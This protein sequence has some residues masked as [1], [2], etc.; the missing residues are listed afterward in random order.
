MFGVFDHA[1]GALSVRV[2]RLVLKI[3]NEADISFIDEN[4]AFGGS[5]SIESL[6]KNEIQ[7]ILDLRYENFDK[8]EEL[9]NH[10]MNYLRIKVRD[11]NVPSLND[12][13]KAISWIKS[14]IQNGK[15]SFCSL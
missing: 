5:S 14:E 15:K 11:G 13:K 2:N 8:S 10:S 6:A 9:K 1:F 7:S 12:T 4:L 3:K